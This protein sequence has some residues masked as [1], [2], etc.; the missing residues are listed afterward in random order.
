MGHPQG[1]VRLVAVLT[2]VLEVTCLPSSGMTL[3]SRDTPA[4]PALSLHHGEL[5]VVIGV[6]QEENQLRGMEKKNWRIAVLALAL[7][8]CWQNCCSI[9]ANF[10]C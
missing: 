7:P 9:R 10:A 5:L 4:L 6:T 3:A 8:R 2:V 1:V